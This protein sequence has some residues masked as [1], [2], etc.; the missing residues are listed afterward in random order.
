[1]MSVEGS[2]R[3]VSVAQYVRDLKRLNRPMEKLVFMDHNFHRVHPRE[4]SYCTAQPGDLRPHSPLVMQN[5]LYMPHTRDPR[6]EDFAYPEEV[7]VEV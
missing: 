2:V 6:M 3:A 4:V 5:F 1:M 7:R